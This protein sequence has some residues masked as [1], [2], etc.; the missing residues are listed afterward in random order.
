MNPEEALHTEQHYKPP[1]TTAKCNRVEGEIEIK[2]IYP[3][4]AQ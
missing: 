2:H 4:R 3:L 1:N